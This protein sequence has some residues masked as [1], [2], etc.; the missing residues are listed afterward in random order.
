[1]IARAAFG[2][3]DLR[4]CGPNRSSGEWLG[5]HPRHR[6]RAHRASL[7]WCL[8]ESVVVPVGRP[9]LALVLAN[10]GVHST[11]PPPPKTQL[12]TST[13]T[14]SSVL[15]ISCHPSS[16][17]ELRITIVAPPATPL[18]SSWSTPPFHHRSH[19][20]ITVVP[21]HLPVI[22]YH[23]LTALSSRS[24]LVLIDHSSTLCCSTW[25]RFC[26]QTS[27]L[28]TLVLFALRESPGPPS[29]HSSR[30]CLRPG[31]L[32]PRLFSPINI[33]SFVSIRC[34]LPSI[35][36]IPFHSVLR[37]TI[38]GVRSSSGTTVVLFQE[39]KRII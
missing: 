3:I 7:N 8:R 31:L 23:H 29:T 33:Q 35:N 21:L 24:L 9:L 6:F 1:M 11:A 27:L 5:A 25:I 38:P 16:R 26:S 15:G 13:R 12:A 39:R 4:C 14:W 22:L 37:H 36:I 2:P 17:F 10:K 19:C 28:P 34:R 20:T 30:S 18:T 32:R